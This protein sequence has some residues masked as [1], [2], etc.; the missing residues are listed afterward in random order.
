VASCAFIKPDGTRCVAGAGADSQWCYN[1]D[2][3]RAEERKA[4]SR[5]GG[6][7]AGRGR[8]LTDLRGLRAENGQLRK[9]M[10]EGEI[11]PRLLAVATQS[12][13]CDIRCLEAEMKAKEQEELEERMEAIEQALAQRSVAYGT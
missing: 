13:N 10:L 8:P 9:R 12:I 1:H 11:D 3:A 7:K 2:P 6:K 4:N 5:K